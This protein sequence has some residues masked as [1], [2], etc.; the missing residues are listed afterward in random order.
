MPDSTSPST[1]TARRVMSRRSM[2]ADAGKLAATAIVTGAL[3]TIVVRA[4]GGGN[5]PAAASGPGTITVPFTHSTEKSEWLQR[6]AEAFNRR[7]V[8]HNDK[9]IVIE[10]DARGSVDALQK[11]VS[12]D[13]RPA[14]WSPAS[15]LEL[16]QLV[17]SWDVTHPGAPIL[18]TQGSLAPRSLV[19]SPLVLLAW[20]ERATLL[21]RQFGG[22]DWQSLHAA[23]TAKGGWGSIA[24]GDTAWGQVKFG[25]TRPDSSNSGVLTLALLAGAVVGTNRP[26][27]V[28]DAHSLAFEQFMRDFEDAVTQFGSSSGTFTE[29]AVSRGPAS[30]DVVATY[31]HL[32]LVKLAAG[33]PPAGPLELYYPNPTLLC[34]HPFAILRS[35]SA[36]QTAAAQL[37]RDFLLSTDQQ[38]LTLTYGFRPSSPSIHLT[39]TGMAGNLFAKSIPGVQAALQSAIAPPPG[40]D[41]VD[42]LIAEWQHF[43]KDRPTN[44]SC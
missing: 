19:S 25:Q 14:A 16:N 28:A 11:I 31:E 18:I 29:C 20:Q 35:A 36:E 12:G 6:A 30:F 40:D 32:A 1:G 34:D 41:V 24:G 8:T 43:Y 10:L 44:S 3:G 37:F 27:S 38:R 21:R 9:R 22:L 13:V 5:P 2:L 23:L 26:L 42:A 33:A 4:A 39:D 17:T 15:T 7:Q